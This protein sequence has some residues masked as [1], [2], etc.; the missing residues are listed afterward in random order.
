MKKNNESNQKKREQAKILYAQ[1]L[2]CSQ[3]AREID[4]PRPTI[5]S[6]KKRDNW[7]KSDI[8]DEVSLAF[9]AR[10]L[11]LIAME[12][13]GNGEY[14]EIDEMM[15]QLERL[16]KINKYQETGNGSDLNPKLKDRY[17][18]NRKAKIKNLFTNEEIQ[19]LE[20][21]FKNILY[22]FQQEW[23][24]IL[25][26]KKENNKQKHNPARIFALLKSRQIGA[27]YIIAIWCLINA[28]QTKKN[29]IFLSA[30]K[31]QAFQFI[32]YIKSFVFET[33]G[34]QIGGDPIVINFEDN[35]SVEFYYMGTNALTAQ[36]R[37]GDVVMD[38]FFW[39]RKFKDFQAV[40]SAMAS[41]SHY[42][43]IYLST[44]STVMHE[45]YGFW[46]GKDSVSKISIDVSHTALQSPVLCVD[47]KW[48]QIVT[49]KDAIKGGY[50][51]LDTSQ[52]EK[53]YTPDRFDN[54][55]MAVFLDDSES[56]FPLSLLQPNMVDSWEVWKDFKPNGN[57]RYH[58]PV[59]VGYDP[60]FTG[61][62]PAIAIIAP[63]T[64][65]HEPYRILERKHLDH[66]PPMVQAQYIKKV[67]EAYQVEFL[68]I[69]VTGA[70]IAV[71]EHVKAFYP[72]YTPINYSVEV[73][74]RMAL[75]AKELF[76]RRKLHF[77]SGYTDIAKSFI[78]IKSV[79]TQGG[80]RMT[81]VSKR[82]QETGHSDIAW[83]I[84][85]ALENAPIASTEPIATANQS[86]IAIHR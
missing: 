68:G 79:L 35:T 41:Q 31:A 4:I 38:E 20:D 70:G 57:K 26:G 74:T 24:E 81:L 7:Q 36:G 69:D 11:S 60:S 14:K 63:P 16:A 49:V 46:T 21:A 75:R 25:N 50:D 17:K 54:L 18:P 15:R 28:L 52:L 37:H 71:A 67:C 65:A 66:L 51:K 9:K 27:T 12:K 76:Y 53:E 77:D 78:A 84:M 19:S 42:Q 40:A 48:R 72:R 22:P 43:Q 82:T 29:K 34:K 13:K 6:W 10:L 30:S 44:P 58:K 55:F 33:L 83:A 3:I 62:K 61:D 39:I 1:G 2:T 5:A 80:G 56:F 32:S 45:A 73:K 47:G 64:Y 59:W 23:I 86:K 85:N 8:F